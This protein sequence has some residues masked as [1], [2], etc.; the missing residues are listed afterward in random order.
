MQ[1]TSP[2]LTEEERQ[3]I[4]NLGFVDPVYFLKFHL[5]HLFPEDVPWFHRG[6]ISILTRKTDFLLKYGELDL[7]VQHF[8][9]KEDQTNPHSPERPLFHVNYNE[10]GEAIS[11]DL[12]VTRFTEF[13]IPRGF[14]K[15]TLIG[16]GIMLWLIEYQECKFPLY[17]SETALHA[18]QQLR[19]VKNELEH[20]ERLRLIFGNVKPDRSASGKWTDKFFETTTGICCAARGRG[21]QVRGMNVNGQRPDRVLCDDLE[22]E[23]S[24]STPEQRRKAVSWFYKAL[25]PVI[26]R[27]DPNAQIMVLGTLL[28]KECLLMTLANDPDWTTV[29]FGA[30][31]RN[32]NPLWALMMDLASIDREKI[33]Y[34]K[35]GQ[36]AGFY[37]EFLS[38]VRNDDTAKFKERYIHH[39]QPKDEIIARAICIDPAISEKIDADGSSIAVVGMTAGG[40]LPVLESWYKV[41]ATPREQVDKY[42]EFELQYNCTH[43]GVEGIAY[44][45]ALIHLL[46][47]EMYRKGRYFEIDNISH[48]IKKDERILGVLQPRYAA[49]YVIHTRVFAA[50]EAQLLEFPQGKKDAP[51]ALA[52]AITL[53]DPVA[54]CAADP[55]K[56]LA[57]DVYPSLEEVFNGDW[58]RK[59]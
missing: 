38:V 39:K 30:I 12:D 59:A 41:G 35:V 40:I 1:E 46:R 28:H 36:L 31:D 19:N 58:R 24:I 55:D 2:T 37:M 45:S 6:I 13:I 54:A 16:I 9:W 3:Q 26:P 42:F 57:D 43:H 25:K 51:D 34:T 56:D 7:I 10:E 23:E 47:E 27:L 48:G 50:L 14:A 17:V 29:R 22:D 44:Q 8:V 52:M 18:E 49:G 11:I 4:F 15:T 5:E 33:S 53:L 21:G 32:G 20:N